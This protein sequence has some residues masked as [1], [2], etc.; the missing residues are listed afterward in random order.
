MNLYTGYGYD[1][2]TNIDVQRH[3]CLRAPASQSLSRARPRGIV[4]RLGLTTSDCNRVASINSRVY[5]AL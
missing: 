2:G 1:S 5:A 3:V 4:A